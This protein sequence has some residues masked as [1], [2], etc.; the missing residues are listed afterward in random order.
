LFEKRRDK[1][2]TIYHIDDL[3]DMLAEEDDLKAIEEAEREFAT[4]EAAVLEMRK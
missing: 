4:G 2:K 1:L 3:E